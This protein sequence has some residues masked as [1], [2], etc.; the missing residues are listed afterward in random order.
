[1]EWAAWEVWGE[2]DSKRVVNLL[3]FTQRKTAMGGIGQLVLAIC[4][5]VLCFYIMKMEKKDA[6]LQRQLDDL[7]RDL[8]EMKQEKN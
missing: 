5:T 6:D 4:V 1:M 3:Y 8:E 7:K 2:W